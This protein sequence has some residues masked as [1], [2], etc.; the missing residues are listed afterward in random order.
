MI[1]TAIALLLIV[2]SAVAAQA[3]EC[4]SVGGHVEG[5][6]VQAM[7]T[8]KLTGTTMTLTG[9]ID[10]NRTPTQKLK[11]RALAKGVLCE[12]VVGRAAVMVMTNG[13]RMTETVTDRVDG[14]EAAGIAYVC[15]SAIRF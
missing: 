13:T 11:C 7:R 10:G 3:V 8:V 9:S 14:H 6:P 15:R 1:R 2:T 4:R 5:T 12:A